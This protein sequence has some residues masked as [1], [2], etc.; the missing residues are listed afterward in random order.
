MTIMTKFNVGD[1]V[2]CFTKTGPLK[3]VVRMIQIMDNN[4]V[5]CWL[6]DGEFIY[7]SNLVG[8]AQELADAF[9]AFIDKN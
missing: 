1:T 4:E 2:Y 7:E 3:S 5:A 8:T 6:E 9:Q